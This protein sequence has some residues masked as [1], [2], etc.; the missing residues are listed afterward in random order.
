[1]NPQVKTK[2]MIHRHLF[3]F[4]EELTVH[5]VECIDD[6]LEPFPDILPG[7]AANI[8]DVSFTQIVERGH[9]V[10]RLMRLVLPHGLIDK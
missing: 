9:P 10:S 6:C 3:S 5:E 8:S 1:M 7:Q 4:R 2:Q